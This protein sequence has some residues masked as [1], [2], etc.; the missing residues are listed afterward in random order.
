MFFGQILF[1]TALGRWNLELPAW[2]FEFQ[3]TVRLKQ[4]QQTT[5]HPDKFAGADDA[6][7]VELAESWSSLV[8]DSYNRLLKPLERAQYLLELSGQP[9][10]EGEIQ[11]SSTRG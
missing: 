11:V 10:A 9:L 7:Q 3:Q 5:L 1:S 6:E 2:K 8:N 4:T